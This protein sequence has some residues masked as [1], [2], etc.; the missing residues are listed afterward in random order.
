MTALN[1]ENRS[2]RPSP[3]VL[4]IALEFTMGDDQ[5]SA[6]VLRPMMRMDSR[7]C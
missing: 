2:I 5:G 4:L 1:Y 6:T 3:P 7:G